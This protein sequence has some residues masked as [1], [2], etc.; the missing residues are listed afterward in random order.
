MTTCFLTIKDKLDNRLG[1]F[2]LLGFDFMLDDSL[3]VSLHITIYTSPWL[4]QLW[5]I[6]TNVNPALHTST[7]TLQQII[8]SMLQ[9]TVG[10]NTI[11]LQHTTTIVLTIA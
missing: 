8:P 9:E 7:A 6:E 10:K 1:F 11:Q 3:K 2:E 4:L 5:L